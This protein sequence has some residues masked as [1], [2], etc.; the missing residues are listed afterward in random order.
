V[1]PGTRFGAYEIV[2]P[3]GAGGMGEVYRAR[4]SRLHRDVALKLLP[5]SVAADPERLAR[6]TR[7]A[8]LLA[9]FNHPNIGAIHGLEKVDAVQSLVLELVEGP[10]L[11]ERIAQGPL[12]LDEAI[13]IARQVT[14]ALE[15]AHEQGIIHRDLKPANIKI[16]P[17]GTVKVLDF[18][19]GKAL[20]APGSQADPAQDP[21]QSPTLTHAATAHGII[22][23]TAA[24]MAPEQAR[25]RQVDRRV[26]IWSFGIV[27]FEMLA[28]SR[29]FGGETISES[30]AAII[31]DEPDW[32]ALPASTPDTIRQLLRRMLEKDPKRRLRD[33]G[34]ARLVL[35]DLQRGVDTRGEATVP[36]ARPRWTTVL[37]W[38]IAVVSVVA[39]IVIA[40]RPEPASS[41]SPS[42][43][44]PPSA[45]GQAAPGTAPELPALKYSLPLPNLQLERTVLPIVSPDG[46]RIVYGSKGQLWL[47]ELDKLEPRPLA[48]TEGAQFPFWS[49]DGQQ[50]AYLSANALWR[51]PIDGSKPTRIAAAHFS[52]G[53]RTPG[54][55]WQRDGTI[56]FAPAV[57]GTGFLAVSSAGGELRET[58]ARDPKVESDFHHPS[59]LPDGEAILFVV[60]RA[61]TGADTIEVMARGVRKTILRL[62]GE[63]VDS[64]VYSPTG[65]LLYQRETTTPG[66]WALPFSLEKLERTGDPFLVVPQGSW[67]AV[68][69]NGLLVYAESELTGLEELVWV[70]IATGA[71]KLALSERFAEIAFPRLS[72]DGTRIAAVVSADTSRRV[73]VADLQR[74]THI[75]VADRVAPSARPTWRDD[76]TVLYSIP[77]GAGEAIASR[78]ADASQAQIEWF[79][80][81][82]P[83]V[84]AGRL[85]FVREEAGNRGVWHVVLPPGDTAAR[86]AAVIQQAPI[87]EN[88]PALSPD[89]RLLAYAHGD[90]GQAE[91]MLRTYPEAT[92]QWQVSLEGGGRPLWNRASDRLFFRD[93]AGQLFVVDVTKKPTVRLSRPRAVPRPPLV[94]ARAGFDVSR[95]GKQLLMIREVKAETDKGP[96]LA[97]VQNWLADFRRR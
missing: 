78:R 48:G 90:Y 79:P 22:L 84:S 47:R 69:A 55:V 34:D 73:I 85:L 58:V 12:P 35:E 33:I 59:L 63:T 67:P 38:A 2:G 28:G 83:N 15:Y 26:D 50:V 32:R 37:P 54:G 95:D 43:T 8:Q 70:D 29:P 56:V 66:I 64:P 71:T 97:V 5:A 21:A 36:S 20:G 23:G 93:T 18:G 45:R 49:P 96:S 80:G 53:G 31:K 52:K 91:V 6:F 40:Q 11:A 10:T 72:P 74:Q 27:L 42:G 39:A 4:D 76:R 13:V 82:Q 14:D 30:M 9:A 92:G 75:L 44:A 77:S 94:I 17:D 41:T 60:D 88:E 16:R 1:R 7:E 65:H 81:M 86:D 68:G 57:N 19:L 3:L 87:N 25:G 62:Q 46:R 24:Y 61:D 89:G 51:V